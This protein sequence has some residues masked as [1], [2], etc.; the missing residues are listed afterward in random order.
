MSTMEKPIMPE[1]HLF[2]RLERVG[3][4][5]KGLVYQLPEQP[6]AT[7]GDHVPSWVEKPTVEPP[8]QPELPVI[9][10]PDAAQLW[11]TGS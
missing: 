5:I 4:F 2:P 11:R 8:V 10:R 3:Q 7:H 6:L 9:E 1:F